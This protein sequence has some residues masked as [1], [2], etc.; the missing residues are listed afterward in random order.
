[1]VTRRRFL[2]TGTKAVL[3]AGFFPSL[4][5]G[6]S[7]LGRR[8]VSPANPI[9]S[10]EFRGL[11]GSRFTVRSGSGKIPLELSK[12]SRVRSRTIPGMGK[13]EE[14]SLA[15]RGSGNSA[16]EQDTYRFEHETAGKF[17][18][19]LVPV[20]KVDKGQQ[21]YQVVFNQLHA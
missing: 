15:F 5:L 18:L 10:S 21:H 3:A 9:T 2:T 16:L 20:D 1:M 14:F 11:E 4:F 12:V 13:T 19:F 8:T 6:R 17:D 7:R